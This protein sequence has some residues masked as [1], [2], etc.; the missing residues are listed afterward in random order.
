MNRRS[1]LRTLGVACAAGSAGCLQTV[2]GGNETQTVLDPPQDRQFDSSDLPYPAHGQELPEFE[3]P[4]PLS[5]KKITPVE[6]DE[7]LLVTGFFATCPV[8]CIR[9]IGQLAGVQHGTV[10]A[11]IAEQVRFLAI[12]FDPE[13]DDADA[14]RAYAEKMNVDME[15]GNWH[16]LRPADAD[17]AKEVVH[18][19]LG[20]QFDR[21]GAGE[22][23]RLPGY[24]FRHISLTFLV[25]P[26]GVVER[27]YLTDSPDHER[28]LSDVK[29]VTSADF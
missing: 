11:G 17:E 24:D 10:D 19:R 22:S 8:E 18:E 6:L 15:A 25:N 20:I 2:M 4:D 21:I 3:L 5:G 12:T 29:T 7:T 1:Y 13:R 26:T 28:V 23:G 14:L 9:L 27:T 16:F